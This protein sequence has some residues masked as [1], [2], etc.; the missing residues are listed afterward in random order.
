[1]TAADVLRTLRERG[2]ELRV[3]GGRLVYR[4]RAGAYGEDLRRMVATCRPELIVLLTAPG[5][6]TEAAGPGP[7]SAAP[8]RPCPVC[9]RGLDADGRCTK[10]FDRLC[11][12]C[13]RM[14]GS[15]FIMTCF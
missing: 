3:E 11:V 9:K 10:C 7:L 4:A 15:Y 6:A 13:G 14:T 5:S 1:M 8:A 12:G 2:V